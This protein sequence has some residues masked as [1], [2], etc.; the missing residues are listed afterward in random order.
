[1]WYHGGQGTAA[2]GVREW[3]WWI[4][5]QAMGSL[6]KTAVLRRAWDV[7]FAVTFR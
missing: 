2:S 6:R 1:M 7:I 4:F 3:E 5:G